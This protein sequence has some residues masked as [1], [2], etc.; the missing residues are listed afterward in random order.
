MLPQNGHAE[1]IQ[2]GTDIH[3]SWQAYRFCPLLPNSKGSLQPAE[4]SRRGVV[5]SAGFVAWA[6]SRSYHLNRVPA[7]QAFAECL[8]APART[9]LLPPGPCGVDIWEKPHCCLD[10]GTSHVQITVKG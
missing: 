6:L 1:R 7:K 2:A 9:A 8:G 3:Q 5:V 10:L 4:S